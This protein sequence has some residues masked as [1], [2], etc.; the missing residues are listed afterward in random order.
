[1]S[2]GAGGGVL[3]EWLAS[4]RLDHFFFE[5]IGTLVQVVSS[6]EPRICHCGSVPPAAAS[7]RCD[8]CA[9]ARVGSCTWWHRCGKLSGMSMTYRDCLTAAI[10]TMQHCIVWAIDRGLSDV[11]RGYT[12][13][14][15]RYT[16]L[17]DSL[18]Q[19]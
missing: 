17:R 4:T 2:K 6:T 11:A 12:E 1:M 14:V 15:I 10:E 5:I 3:S 7:R 18:P 16:R 9:G 13:Q 19:S 8:E